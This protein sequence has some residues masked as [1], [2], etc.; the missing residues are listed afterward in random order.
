MHLVQP[1]K[2]KMPPS[3]QK[4]VPPK[5]SKRA[6]ESTDALSMTMVREGLLRGGQ[7]LVSMTDGAIFPI[8]IY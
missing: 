4:T 8:T 6:N 7:A 5:P 3:P 1:T 2:R